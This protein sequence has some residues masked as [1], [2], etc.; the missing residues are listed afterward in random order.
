MDGGR[1]EIKLT[2]TVH[3]NNLPSPDEARA[4]IRILGFVG[5]HDLS[6]AELAALAG[7]MVKLEALAENK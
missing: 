6:Q 7:L 4:G 1:G 3:I 2:V 5:P